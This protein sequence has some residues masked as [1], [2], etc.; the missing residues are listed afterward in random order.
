MPGKSVPC[1]SQRDNVVFGGRDIRK[2]Y[3]GPGIRKTTN[4][5]LKCSAKFN[6]PL[7]RP[8]DGASVSVMDSTGSCEDLGKARGPETCANCVG[9]CCGSMRDLINVVVEYKEAVPN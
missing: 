3:G 6:K 7:R 1:G 2:E 8:S 9:I 5:G 4:T